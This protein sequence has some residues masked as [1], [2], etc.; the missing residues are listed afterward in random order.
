MG[1]Q[2]KFSEEV[3]I[4][5]R[6]AKAFCRSLA[7]IVCRIFPMKKNKVV[8]WTFEGT[9]G[10]CCNPKYIAD[11]MIRRQREGKAEFEMVWLTEQNDAEFPEEIRAVKSTLWNRAYHLSTAKVWVGNTRTFYGTRKRKEQTYI[12]TWHGTICIK[13]IG[14]YRGELFP[15]IAYLVS[16]RDSD[17]ADYVLSGC[18]WCD[19][20][21]RDGL[22]YDGEILRTGMPRCDI[23]MDQGR[24]ERIREQLREEYKVPEYA[25]VLM[26]APTFRGGSQSTNRSVKTEEATIDFEQLIQNLE[27][28]FGGEWYIFLRLHPQLAA[29]KQRLLTGC[30]SERLVD[31]TARQD[32]NELIAASDAFISDYSSAIFEAMLLKIPCFLYADDLEAYIADRGDLFWDMS[33][34]PFPLALNNQE[35]QRNVVEFDEEA[36]HEELERFIVQ[37][38]VR[39]DGHASQRVVDLIAGKCEKG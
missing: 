30:V 28:R 15:K 25:K 3:Y 5:K 14:K 29:K 37:T 12:Q 4:V 38:G 21:Y 26:Y 17:L 23:L 9:R 36:Y 11:E 8:F 35:L 10:Y 22:I 32:M 2:S 34:L 19:E 7:Y 33:A 16:K 39:E 27:L 13:P 1:S 18:D 6:K 24:R 20:H 31:V